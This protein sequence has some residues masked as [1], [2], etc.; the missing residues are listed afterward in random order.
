MRISDGSSDVCSSD[1]GIVDASSFGDD[2]APQTI[3]DW[4]SDV[5][6]QPAA[7]EH[8]RAQIQS[9]LRTT[10]STKGLLV[11]VTHGTVVERSA[12]RR[13]GKECVSTVRFRWAP[14]H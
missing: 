4:K 10:G 6:P 5:D 3:I 13:V 7:V 12:E 11:F 1:L 9:Y 8:Y 14:Y 2:G